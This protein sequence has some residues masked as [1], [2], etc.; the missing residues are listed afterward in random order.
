MVCTW[1]KSH[2]WV[3]LIKLTFIRLTE[4][5]KEANETM[6]D[7]LY[8]FTSLLW[9]W[10]SANQQIFKSPW[11]SVGIVK[12]ILTN[13]ALVSSSESLP[14][15]AAVSIVPRAT[16]IWSVEVESIRK[17]IIRVMSMYCT[18]NKCVFDPLCRN[19]HE[20]QQEWWY[21]V[22]WH[23]SMTILKIAWASCLENGSKFTC[24]MSGPC[25]NT[26]IM[27]SPCCTKQYVQQ[28][29]TSLTMQLVPKLF[30]SWA[31]I[32]ERSLLMTPYHT[33]GVINESIK[34]QFLLISPKSI[35]P[36]KKG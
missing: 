33:V 21:I 8:F 18:A 16:H 5:L 19:L 14:A 6:N 34:K 27:F 9:Q 30:C 32:M 22:Q 1:V 4:Q 7:A 10:H 11:S 31:H 24:F 13:N 28:H 2:K 3:P 35:W 20:M 29:Y 17:S 12:V 15:W 36:E 26:E 25:P 23:L